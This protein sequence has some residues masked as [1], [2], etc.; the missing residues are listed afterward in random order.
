M[1]SS[2]G[3]QIC[4]SQKTLAFLLELRT[5]ASYTRHISQRVRQTPLGTTGRLSFQAAA[6]RIQTP[7]LRTNLRLRNL[8]LELLTLHYS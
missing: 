3:A 6:C 4:S 1:F 2:Q 8:L 7:F 5:N